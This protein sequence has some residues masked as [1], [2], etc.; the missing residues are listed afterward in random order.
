MRAGVV[1]RPFVSRATTPA[2]TRLP[3]RSRDSALRLAL[4]KGVPCS[5]LR[6]DP[7]T[8]FL[9]Q[10][11]HRCSW[12]G[13]CRAARGS[14]RAARAQRRRE[15]YEGTDHDNKPPGGSA[16]H[17]GRVWRLEGAGARATRQ[18]WTLCCSD[19][20]WRTR[21]PS[22]RC[23]ATDRQVRRGAY[24]KHR[25]VA[26]LALP[27]RLLGRSFRQST[28]WRGASLPSGAGERAGNRRACNRLAQ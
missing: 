6:F 20:W 18:V 26:V 23:R 24:G 13:Q 1:G 3:A 22:I 5:P 11:I 19:R 17:G 16:D 28:P 12:S 9:D 21:R 25:G 14:E 27:S 4:R 2:R 15:A 8:P 7:G 10:H